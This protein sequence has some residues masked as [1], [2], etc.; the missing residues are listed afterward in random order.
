MYKRQ[1]LPKEE[2]TETSLKVEEKEPESTPVTATTEEE[3]I[4]S[5]PES[6]VENPTQ[7]GTTNR[8]KTKYDMPS[9]TMLDDEEEEE[10]AEVSEM[11]KLDKDLLA[12]TWKAYID[13]LESPSVKAAFQKANATVKDDITIAVEVG[14]Q[15]AKGMIQ[16]EKELIPFIRKRIPIHN[17]A[18]EI[19]IDTTRSSQLVKPKKLFSPKEKYEMMREKNP[20]VHELRLR[21]DLKPDNQ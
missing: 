14:S 6:I 17:L 19:N 4:V 16:Q 8:K 7:N 21:L 9:L 10:D 20:M 11:V 1:T 12:N 5:E 3:S 18:M 13:Q 2:V 15:M